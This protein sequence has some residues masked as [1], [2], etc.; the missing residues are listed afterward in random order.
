MGRFDYVLPIYHLWGVIMYAGIGETFFGGIVIFA[1]LLVCGL[2]LHLFFWQANR[3]YRVDPY[4][5]VPWVEVVVIATVIV[6][7]LF[8]CSLTWGL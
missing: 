7:G 2:A 3:N 8:I 6:V 1:I 5:T 4:A